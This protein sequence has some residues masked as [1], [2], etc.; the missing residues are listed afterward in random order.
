MKFDSNLAWTQ[1]LSAVRLNAGVLVPVAGVFFLLPGLIGTWFFSDVYT[2]MLA[3]LGNPQAMDKAMA[4]QTGTIALLGIGSFLFQMTGYM[5]MLGLMAD[6]RR[7]TVGD[8]MA[9]AVRSLPALIGAV[10]VFF[11]GYLLASLV[12]VTVASV[13][14]ASAP[15]SVTGAVV[16]LALVGMAYVMTRLSLTLPVIVIDGLRNPVSAL[17]SSWRITQG[18]ALRIFVFYLLLTLGLALL[19][20]VAAMVVG[21]VIGFG[22]MASGGT[23]GTAAVTGMGLFGGV[24]AALIAM[25]FS[26]ILAAIHRQLSHAATVVIG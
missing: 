14:L 17:V 19:Y 16:G 10:V 3:N 25:M 11:F 12:V 8:A 7:P 18:N 15:S 5:T 22:N 6:R 1:A 21:L 13:L 2:A 4:G 20:L 9:H 23:P 26:G 24:A